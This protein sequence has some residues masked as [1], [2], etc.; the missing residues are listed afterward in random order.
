MRAM[1]H[2][3]VIVFRMCKLDKKRFKKPKIRFYVFYGILNSFID[4]IYF[5]Q[6]GIQLD[7]VPA[8]CQRRWDELGAHH[9][10]G[11]LNFVAAIDQCDLPGGA[12]S[13]V[14]GGPLG[15]RPLPDN[16]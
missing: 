12:D 10:L 5:L 2:L 11:H 8:V 6:Y 7:G 13:L 15:G 3:S 9:A 16:V 4:E 14:G 1:H